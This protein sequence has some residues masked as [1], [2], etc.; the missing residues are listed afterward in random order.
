MSS[1]QGPKP[2]QD[3]TESS[4]CFYLNAITVLVVTWRDD[5]DDW[6]NGAYRED[7]DTVSKIKTIET[8]KHKCL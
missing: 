6:Y 2:K 1:P 3:K 5:R 4:T 7:H 8:Y